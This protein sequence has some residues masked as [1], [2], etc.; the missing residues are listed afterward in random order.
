MERW[1]L[2]LVIVDCK[3]DQSKI[4]NSLIFAGSRLA[5]ASGGLGR[6]DELRHSLL[7]GEEIF[8]E[9][10]LTLQTCT[11]EKRVRVRQMWLRTGSARSKRTSRT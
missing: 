7:R 5:S 9:L 2:R 11:E 3:L 4:C 6:D 10:T 1:N 8:T